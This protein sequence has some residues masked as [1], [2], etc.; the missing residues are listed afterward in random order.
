MN[1]VSSGNFYGP[2]PLP[3]FYSSHRAPSAF[4][5]RNYL[6]DNF[7]NSAI[8]MA[9]EYLLSKY[10]YIVASLKVIIDI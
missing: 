6:L 7:D 1:D 5:S 8:A 9:A 2:F 4:K 10:T 3:T